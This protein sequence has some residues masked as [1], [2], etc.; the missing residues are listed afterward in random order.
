MQSS[1]A[2]AWERQAAQVRHEMAAWRVAHPRAT[3]PQIEQEEARVQPDLAEV[4]RPVT[5]LSAT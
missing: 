1:E 5:R 3:M 2:A 4:A